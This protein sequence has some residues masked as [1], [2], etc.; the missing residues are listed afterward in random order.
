MA[1]SQTKDGSCRVHPPAACV[2]YRDLQGET[3]R[4]GLIAE[5]KAVQL[6]VQKALQRWCTDG[7]SDLVH[8]APA[9][10]EDPVFGAG[11]D[12]PPPT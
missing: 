11:A 9:Q 12:Y 6:S 10:P 8:P 4:P 3:D 1:R 2:E 7:C 5:A